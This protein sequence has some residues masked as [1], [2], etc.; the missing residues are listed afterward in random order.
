VVRSTHGSDRCFSSIGCVM[1]LRMDFYSEVE[2][3][4]ERVR[5]SDVRDDRY[6]KEETSP[7]DEVDVEL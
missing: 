3:A 7:S 4:R 6:S 2:K 5:R 1:I